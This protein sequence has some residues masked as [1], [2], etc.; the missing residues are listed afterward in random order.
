MAEQSLDSLP[1]LQHL[2]ICEIIIGS[3]Y[4]NIFLPPAEIIQN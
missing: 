1:I 3:C 4:R 2:S